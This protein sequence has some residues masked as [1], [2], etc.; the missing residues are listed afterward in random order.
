VGL[1]GENHLATRGN[2]NHFGITTGGVAE[3]VRTL[4]ATEIIRRYGLRFK[5]EHS[6]KQAVRLIGSFAYRFWM[7]DMKP[8]RRRSG[9]PISGRPSRSVP[10]RSLQACKPNPVVRPGAIGRRIAKF[11]RRFP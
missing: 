2:E 1:H 4:S 6:F 11:R 5:I 8:L 10:D 3:H 9:N 7:Q